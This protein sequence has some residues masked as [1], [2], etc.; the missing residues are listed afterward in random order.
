[1]ETVDQLTRGIQWLAEIDGPAL[2]E[3]KVNQGSRKDLGR[4]TRS[5]MQN[6]VDFMNF[7]SYE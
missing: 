7:L 2:L 5:P 3:V 1:M 4:P 6:K